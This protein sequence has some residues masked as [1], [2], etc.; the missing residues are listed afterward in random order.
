MFI[1]AL[2]VAAVLALSY[3]ALGAFA[4]LRIRGVPGTIRWV[5]AVLAAFWVGGFIQLIR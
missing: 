2:L 1:R 4:F 5:L 3:W